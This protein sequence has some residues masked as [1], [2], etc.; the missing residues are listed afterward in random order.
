[1]ATAAPGRSPQLAVVGVAGDG[2]VA[3]WGIP[4]LSQAKVLAGAPHLLR[5]FA[6]HPARKIPLTGPVESW[7]P[8]LQQE[9]AQGSLVLLASGDPLFFG[10]GAAVDGVFPSGAVGLL[11]AGEL[12]AAGPEPP[13]DPLAG[14][15]HPQPARA[16]SGAVGSRS[17]A[18]I[19]CDR[20]AHRSGAY[21]DRLG[22]VHCRPAAAGALPSLGL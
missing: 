14:G 20:G 12:G 10:I 21:T 11:S 4:P 17:Q 7:I 16:G 18:G 22:P 8:L 1:M 13:A 19:P 15:D 6:D 9:M 2:S 5:H 3:S